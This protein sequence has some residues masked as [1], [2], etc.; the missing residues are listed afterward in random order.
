MHPLG[1]RIFEIRHS[2][3]VFTDL[4]LS[5]NQLRGKVIFY[6][7]IVCQLEVEIQMN[8][9]LVTVGFQNIQR[10]LA[11]LSDFYC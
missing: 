2:C 7:F 11:T 5:S 3:P 10:S 1:K 8:R 4:F 6:L 9:L